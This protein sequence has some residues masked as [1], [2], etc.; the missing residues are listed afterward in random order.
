VN[1][2]GKADKLYWNY[3]VDGG[4]V[5]TYLATGSGN[6]SSSAT[7]SA[8]SSNSSTK[9]FFVDVNGDGKADKLYWNYTVDGGQVRLYLAT[10]NGNFNSSCGFSEGSTNS[11][12]RFYFADVTGD[13]KADKIYW[14][15]TVNGGHVRV[16]ISNGSGF[17]STCLYIAGSNSNSTN[18]YFANVD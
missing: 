12:T 4:Q 17:G 15:P 8:G 3:T 6:F 2:D 10:T 14:N 1:G 13:G 11:S 5:R 16:Y 18:F 7:L 9:F